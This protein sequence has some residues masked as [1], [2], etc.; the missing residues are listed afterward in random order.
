[1]IQNPPR[2]ADKFLTWYCNP[3]LL[4]D[5]QGDA[6]E[7]YD[8]RCESK[9]RVAADR[10]FVWDVIRFFRQMLDRFGQIKGATKDRMLQQMIKSCM[11]L[12]TDSLSLV[13]TI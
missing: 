6:Y 12:I 11:N 4:E 9:G 13:D 1:M 10:S 7:L 3:R 5:I 8:R 2:W